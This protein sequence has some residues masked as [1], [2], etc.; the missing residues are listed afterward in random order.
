MVPILKCN[1]NFSLIRDVSVVELLTVQSVHRLVSNMKFTDIIKYNHLH[2]VIRPLY[3]NA[4]SHLTFTCLVLLHQHTRFTTCFQSSLRTLWLWGMK[5]LFYICWCRCW[6]VLLKTTHLH[7]V[8][9][10][11]ILPH[12]CTVI[13]LSVFLEDAL[14]SFSSAEKM[15]P[16]I[17]SNT[18]SKK[19]RAQEGKER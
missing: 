2:R 15:P 13:F 16:L 8:W 17:R 11:F 10:I 19:D 9:C 4:S 5:R 3:L 1:R 12:F 14:D 18:Y 6:T 7:I